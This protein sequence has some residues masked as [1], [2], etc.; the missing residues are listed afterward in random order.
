MAGHGTALL[1]GGTGR[2]YPVL[3]AII[4]INAVL[5]VLANLIAD[6]LYARLD[7]RVRY[8]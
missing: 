4:M 6:M 3:M 5:I 2:D 1:G 7:P 8:E